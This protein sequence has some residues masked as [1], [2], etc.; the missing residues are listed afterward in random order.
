MKINQL[1]CGAAASAFLLLTSHSHAADLRW[2]GLDFNT[3]ALAPANALDQQNTRFSITPTLAELAG[4][5]FGPGAN[6]SQT[7]GTTTATS[8][9]S[10]ASTGYFINTA[11]DTLTMSLNHSIS[12]PIAGNNFAGSEGVFYFFV[13]TPGTLSV[14]YDY[15]NEEATEPTAPYKPTERGRSFVR[16]KKNARGLGE[17]DDGSSETVN[18]DGSRTFTTELGPVDDLVALQFDLRILEEPQPTNISGGYLNLGFTPVPEPASAALL[19]LGALGLLARR[20]ARR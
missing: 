8:G 5:P 12:G 14:T 2:L 13:L 18:R 20:C 4:V 7:S 16:I 6:F 11:A 15:G 17:E 3:L 19:G 9:T 1:L 10:T